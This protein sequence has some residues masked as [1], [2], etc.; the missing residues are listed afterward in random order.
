LLEFGGEPN[1]VTLR[2]LSDGLGLDSDAIMEAMD[3]DR[4]TDEINQTR[5]LARRMQISGT[6]SFVLGSEM[7][8]GYL[9]ADQ[10]LQIA[11]AVRAEQG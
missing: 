4:V 6:P 7:L 3:S 5:E 8:R 11:D 9:T 1:E 10:M 2:R